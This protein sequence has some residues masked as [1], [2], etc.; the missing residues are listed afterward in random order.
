MVFEHFS[1]PNIALHCLYTLV[2][3]HIHNLEQVST[4]LS[5]TCDESRPQG[6][7]AEIIR[8]Q[9]S[10]FSVAFHDL[11]NGFV[12]DCLIACLVAFGDGSKQCALSNASSLQVVFQDAA[13]IQLSIIDGDSLPLRLLVG[14]G[15]ADSNLCPIGH[16]LNI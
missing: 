5:R 6:M 8:I 11:S 15:F 4:R 13:Y 12:G 9:S 3:R 14:L 7:P 10:R 2:A 16:E 1:V